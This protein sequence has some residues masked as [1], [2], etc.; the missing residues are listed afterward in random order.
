[1]M[2]K[3]FTREG[4]SRIMLLF[5]GVFMM[6]LGIFFFINSQLG[7]DPITVLINGLSQTIGITV[8][9][10]SFLIN[11]GII[12]LLMIFT[13]RRFG[14]GTVLHAVFVGLFLD[15]LFFLFGTITP[16]YMPLRVVMLLTA[17]LFIGSG[18]AIY[19]SAEMGEGAIEALMMFLQDKTDFSLKAV[20]V[21]MDVVFGIVGVILGA[22]FGIGT[23]L[24][25]FAIGPVTQKVFGYVQHLKAHN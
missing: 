1:M 10:T 18:I 9:Q 14:I 12:L 7:S 24:G 15:L 8:G 11:G 17:P 3:M 4:I 25:A 20:K 22:T 13:G 19:V 23:I 5:S 21:C 16:A 2:R 6:S